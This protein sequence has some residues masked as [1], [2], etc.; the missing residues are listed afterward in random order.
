MQQCLVALDCSSGSRKAECGIAGNGGAESPPCGREAE[1]DG[2]DEAVLPG[3]ETVLPGLE[4]VLPVLEMVH[5]GLQT[6]LPGLV[7]MRGMPERC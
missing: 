4:T 5:P 7:G 3:L 2:K 6:V 1:T